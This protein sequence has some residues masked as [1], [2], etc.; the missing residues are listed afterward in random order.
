MFF[1]LISG[2][3]DMSRLGVRMDFVAG[4]VEMKDAKGTWKTIKMRKERLDGSQNEIY[5][6]S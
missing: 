6:C 2:R 5:V 3:G 4:E 1:F